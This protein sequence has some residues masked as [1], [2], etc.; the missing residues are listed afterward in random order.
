MEFKDYYAILG[1]PRTASEKEIKAAYRR[2]ARRYHPDVNKGQAQAEA[3]FK[4][5][6]EA[7]EVLSDPQKRRQYDEIAAGGIPFGHAARAEWRAA[8]GR[9]RTRRFSEFFRTFFGGGQGPRPGKPRPS[10]RPTGCR[11]TFDAARGAHLRDTRAQRRRPQGEASRR[12]CEGARVRACRRK[13][14]AAARPRGDVFRADRARPLLLERRPAEARVATLESELDPDSR[15]DPVRPHLPAARPRP[16]E[17]R[18]RA[19]GPVGQ[20]GGS[21]AG[22]PRRAPAR[23]VRVAAARGAVSRVTGRAARVGGAGSA[24]LPSART[25]HRRRKE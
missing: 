1:V 3:R 14:A 11:S 18:R 8:N 13:A 5:V 23:V 4:E 15:T 17:G 22:R 12:G 7:Y 9:P 21:P 2:L 10:R 19:R 25:R 24:V 16:P 6:G 20:P